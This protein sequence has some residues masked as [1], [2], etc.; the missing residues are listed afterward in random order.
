V[1]LVHGVRVPLPE[2]L[3]GARIGRVARPCLPREPPRDAH[4]VEAE[5]TARTR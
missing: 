2:D 3:G 5:G 1:N 4:L